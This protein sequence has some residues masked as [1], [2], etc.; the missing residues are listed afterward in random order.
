[1][2]VEEKIKYIQKHIE[3]VQRNCKEIGMILVGLGQTK[4]GL[5]V[6]SNGQIHDNSK[7]RGFEFAHLFPNDPLLYEAVKQH[8][9][10]NPHHPEYWANG[11]HD[12]PEEYII[13]MVCDWS[14]RGSEF[15]TDVYDWI[16]DEATKKYNFKID[17][18]I[19]K[20]ITHYLGLLLSRPFSSEQKKLVNNN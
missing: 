18:E 3:N 10:R 16:K 12:M 7:F 5:I 19:G 14:A 1:M 9:S 4:L 6:I 15:G 11:I 13:E 17:D 8:Q 20:K 2:T